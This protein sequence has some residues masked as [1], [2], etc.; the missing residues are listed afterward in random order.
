MRSDK[1][2]SDPNH[3]KERVRELLQYDILDT[4]DE[5]EFDDITKV[6]AYLFDADC[7]LINFLDHDRQW[8]KS[9]VNWELRVLPRNESVCT[10]TI[11]EEKYLVVNDLTKD[12]R[13]KNYSYVSSKKY[14][15]YAG[16]VL[17]S[18]HG[19]NIGTICVLDN[20]P[21]KVNENQLEG[22]KV[23][24]AAV[25]S[26]LELRLKREQL[27]KEHK[28]LRK[29]ATFLRNSTDVMM[30]LDS[31]NFEITEIKGEVRK[32]L[33]YNPEEMRETALTEY[34][35]DREFKKEFEKWIEN[36]T[37]EKSSEEVEF[38]TKNGQQ[39]WLQISVSKIRGQY[40]VTARNITRRKRTEQRLLKQVKFTEGI[41][42]HLP[43]I[44]F[45]IDSEG[46]MRK[47]NSN[48]EEISKYTSVEL[49]NKLYME[50][51]AKEDHRVA[52]ESLQQVQSEGYARREL[53]IFSK[54]GEVIPHLLVSFKFQLHDDNYVIGIG[55]DITEEKKA[56]EEIKSKEEKLHTSLNEKEVLLQEI[57]HRVKNN[58][59]IVSGLFQLEI[60]NT[61]DKQLQYILSANQM[62]IKSMALIHES[63]YSHSDFTDIHFGKYLEELSSTIFKTFT[64]EAESLKLELDTDSL[65]LNINQAIPCALLVNELLINALKHAF[66]DERDGK[67]KVTLREKD[68]FVHLSVQDNGVG[69]D[70]GVNF[71]NPATLGLKLISHL[72]KQLYGD[73]KADSSE[74][75]TFTVSFRKEQI[76][77]SSAR[78]IPGDA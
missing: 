3:E 54:E 45:L 4:P 46:R 52:Q 16:V 25:E 30:I 49:K 55:I 23:L 19:Y 41:L 73:I 10:F 15:F 35:M 68:G 62:R 20:K 9:C 17:Q 51:I 2:N 12:D 65:S 14:Q 8:T 57:H 50:L 66:P 63:L 37:E 53:K 61:E 77:G 34:L 27:I 71:E 48:L 40:F 44:F 69:L 28:K 33:G 24:G 59:A 31:K 11:Q 1:Y 26:Q 67:I 29:S 64:A 72:V 78:Y 56:L 39:L 36:S 32:L 38:A 75:T 43:G 5:E 6:A 74:G 22:L 18:S 60:Y 70:P 58:L 21:Q 13:F 47:W 42:D 76:K 7:A